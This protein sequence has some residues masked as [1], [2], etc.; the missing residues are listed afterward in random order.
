MPIAG[1][2]I[3]AEDGALQR[4]GDSPSLHVRDAVNVDVSPS[5]KILLRPLTERVTD[6]PIKNLWQ[7][8]LHSD[9][10]GTL[11]DQWVKV[12]P[13][14]WTT[15]PLARIGKGIVAHEVVNNQVY[16]AGPN[17][18]FVFD[19]NKATSLTIDTP[20]SPMLRTDIGGLDSGNYGVAIAYIRGALESATS[21][22]ASVYTQLGAVTVHFP[23]CLD[24]TVTAIR[25]YA[26]D[27]DG[28][29]LY[30]IEDYPP[31]QLSAPLIMKLGRPAQFRFLSPMPTG[32]YFKY[33]RGRLITAKANI[34]RFSEAL[35][36]HLHDERSGFVQMP[37]R[38]TFVQPADSGIWVGQVDHVVFLQGSQPDE[39]I[40]NR[41]NARAPVPD[42]AIS[43][44]AEVVGSEVAQGG[45]SVALWLAENGYVIGTGS[46]Q[47]IELHAGVMKGITGQSATSVVL[48][49]RLL[50][51]VV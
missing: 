27:C 22:M 14:D 8:P 39:L 10:F 24:D 26:T 2:N 4:G 33:W 1:M 11:D 44:P 30:F 32:K 23:L 19:G 25:L 48:D 18:I 5:G 12:N 51:T 40:F 16:A 47:I 34:L 38:I 6:Q 43:I 46:G 15:E 21:E 45:A 42:S 31:D 13:L 20:P 50:T 49:R 41:K 29:Q 37:Q 9:T 35:A 28:S 36:Y 17:G 3:V 7:S